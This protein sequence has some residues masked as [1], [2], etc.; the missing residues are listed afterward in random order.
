VKLAGFT[1][2]TRREARRLAFWLGCK[3]APGLK[4]GTTKKQKK[5]WPVESGRYT[6]SGANAAAG[7]ACCRLVAALQTP[8]AEGDRYKTKEQ[9]HH[10]RRYTR[11]S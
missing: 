2:R 7:L 9:G 10:G 1:S 8:A 5:K 6:R 11:R 3:K 4:P